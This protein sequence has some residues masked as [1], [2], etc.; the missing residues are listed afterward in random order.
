[1]AFFYLNISSVS[2]G[3]GRSAVA[4]AAYRA[5]ERLREE[6]TGRLH[7]HSHRR[8]V[9]HTEIFV[10]EHFAGQ[11]LEWARNRERLWNTADQAEKRHNSRVAREY[12]VT[13]PSELNPEQRLFLARNFSREITE[14]YGVAVDLAVHDPRPDG[15][16][17][18]FHA[19]LLTT[20]REVTPTGLGAKIGLD[21]HT[22][23]RRRRGLPN[24]RDEY[25]NVRERWGQLTNAA[26]REAGIDERID[27]RSYAAQGIDR[28][29]KP[30]IPE[31]H[32]RLERRG[33]RSEVAEQIRAQYQERVQQRLLQAQAK[34]AGQGASVAADPGGRSPG[35]AEPAPKADLAEVRR[36]AREAWLAL[37]A[38]VHSAEAAPREREPAA[39]ERQADDD[40]TR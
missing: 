1:M 14:R 35:P 25:V 11:S 29:P 21:M 3:A 31:P 32:L 28:E 4:S 40:L 15:D 30:R 5:G 13:L 23:D 19:H 33:V 38:T 37:R 27:H 6:R 36:Q 39:P 7:N 24:H 18:N 2:R 17:R 26:L 34:A 12:Q 22:L 8:D 10:P 20:T 9:V 16:P